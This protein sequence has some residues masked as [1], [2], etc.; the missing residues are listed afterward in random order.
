M[1]VVTVRFRIK[2]DHLQSFTE[3]MIQNA[4]ESLRS[5]VG[6]HQFDVCTDSTRPGDIFLYEIYADAAAFDLH[7]DSPH[8]RA[9]DQQTQHMFESKEVTVFNQLSTADRPTSPRGQTL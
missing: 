1:H 8:F 3:L 2:T 5:E 6:C 9:F 4:S 7:L